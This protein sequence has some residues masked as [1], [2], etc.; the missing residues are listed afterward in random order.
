RGGT[1]AGQSLWRG[2]TA[3]GPGVS[4]GAHNM[5]LVPFIC[6]FGCVL[7]VGPMSPNYPGAP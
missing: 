3:R 1:G 2:G 7:S 4:R 6:F 5:P